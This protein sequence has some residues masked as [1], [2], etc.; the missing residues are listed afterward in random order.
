MKLTSGSFNTISI[1]VILPGSHL[2]SRIGGFKFLV[3]D[4][5]MS[6]VLLGW[7]FLKSICVNL[8]TSPGHGTRGNR[9][10]IEI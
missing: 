1:V 9:A 3:V 8:K 4:Q 10:Q 6:K 7:P 2:P 5:N